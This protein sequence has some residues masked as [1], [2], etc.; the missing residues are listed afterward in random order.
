MNLTTDAKC[1]DDGFSIQSDIFRRKPLFEQ[2]KRLI[3]EA[4]DSNLV[5]ALDDVWGSGKTSFVKMLHSELR[6]HNKDEI[7]VIYFDAFENDYQSDPFIS[8]SSEL[9][10]LL[11]SKGVGADD[12]AKNVL[13]TAS[14]IGVRV[15]SGGA[16]IAIS[17]LT[18]G[19]VS[20]T[21]LENAGNLISESVNSEIE[22]FVE[23]KI[24]NMNEE[25]KAIVDFKTA[26]ESIYSDTGRKTLIIIDEMDRAR[27]DY[28]LELLEKIKHLFS[29]K[30]LVFFLVMNRE[31]FEKG[32]AYR[33]GDINTTLY[34]N[35]FIHY[36]FSLP[37]IKSYD[38]PHVHNNMSTT[39]SDYMA[40]LLRENNSLGI[41]YNGAFAKCI[42]LLLE[43]NGCSFREA[44]R[45]M[46]TMLV[47]ENHERIAI[48][49]DI[50]YMTALA[51][52]SFLK[53]V[54][55]SI[56]TKI[57]RKEEDSRTILEKLNIRE[58][59]RNDNTGARLLFNLLDYH[60]RDE[61]DIKI[62]REKKDPLIESVEGRWGEQTFHILDIANSLDTLNIQ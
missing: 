3:L 42:S 25:K 26:L 21:M 54:N 24:K 31:Q 1:F 17:A 39:I 10:A 44:E 23:S 19:V 47:V 46:S 6:I 43:V 58:N 15:F 60:Y 51:L 49:D 33:Y 5:F 9:Y 16:K 50:S 52:V 38:F 40:R 29:V 62:L 14:K 48:N 8:I 12:V 30:G 7:D 4:P 13:K 35:K 32:I 2:M 11:K 27:P 57:L 55:P 36:W 61:D 45:C 53:V 56:L 59:S 41:S 34:L 22:S 20:G 18:A 37:K 28:S